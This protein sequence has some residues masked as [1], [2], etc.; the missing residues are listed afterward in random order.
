MFCNTP[1]FISDN[2]G[3]SGNVET[4]GKAKGRKYLNIENIDQAFDP[5]FNFIK[6]ISD[7]KKRKQGPNGF[8][9]PKTRDVV[10]KSKSG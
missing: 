5:N 9:Q 1:V 6:S 4:S 10:S 2:A 7:R 8:R 3:I